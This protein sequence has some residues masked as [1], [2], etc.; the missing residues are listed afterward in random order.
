[1]KIVT[2]VGAR[3][4]FVKAAVVSKAFANNRKDITEIIVHT[5][6]HFDANMSN[7]FFDELEIPNPN[8]NLNISSGT[9]GQN[10]GRMIEG[11]EKVLLEE[12]PSWVIV[13]GDTDSTLAGTI[14]AAKLH[15]PV[16]HIEAG[17]RSFNKR[18]PE[19]INRV[20]TDHASTIL[21]TPTET[22]IQNLKNEGISSE[23]IKLV[24]DV[25]YDATLYYALKAKEIPNLN[26][27]SNF[28]LT[29]IHR[30][31]NTNEP[32]KLKCI[33]NAL[34]YIALNSSQVILPLHPR[35]NAIIKNEDIDISKLTII[36]P[37]GYLEMLWLLKNCSAV[38]TDSGGLQKEAFFF[39][40]PCLTTRSETEWVELVNEGVNQLVG[41][42]TNI[43]IN[44]YNNIRFPS[45]TKLLY[46]AGNA[47]DEI[48]NYF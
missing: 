8:Y 42:N 10:T 36:D 15:I 16:A 40:K 32:E 44:A 35:T 7:V 27:S 3:P 25:M 14:A 48:V 19:E 11:I 31:E 34:N 47:A 20:L 23:K 5:G 30:A 24:G 12:K 6:Q 1:M 29:T 22:A 17:L 2:I 33:I 28:I 38:I 18:M 13:Y 41:A 4:Q 9:H 26:I 43:I 39:Q 21:F 45:D 37:V 46:G